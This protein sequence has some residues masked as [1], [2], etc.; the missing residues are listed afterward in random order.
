MR[1]N[2]L[3]GM[4]IGASALCLV[5]CLALPFMLLALPALSAVLGANETVHV[6]IL[7]FALPTSAYA[8]VS[9]LHD[10]H[11]ILPLVAGSLGLAL[12]AFGLWFGDR[13]PIGVIITVVGSSLLASGHLTNWRYRKHAS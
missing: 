9:G 2:W 3:D 7:L 1:H 6:L 8:L 13:P 10:H 5:H 4:A 11:Q 12:L